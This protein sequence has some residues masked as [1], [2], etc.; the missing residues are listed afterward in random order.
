MGKGMALRWL[1]LHPSDTLALHPSIHP[2][3]YP[4]SSTPPSPPTSQL[5]GVLE[6]ISGIEKLSAGLGGAAAAASQSQQQQQ[7]Q[8][9]EEMRRGIEAGKRG[10]RTALDF[11]NGAVGGN[12]MGVPGEFA[13]S[14]E[15]TWRLVEDAYPVARNLVRG[16]GG[17]LGWGTKGGLGAGVVIKLI[18]YI[19]TPP[20]R[21]TLR[22]RNTHRSSRSTRT[23][24][25]RARSSPSSSRAASPTSRAARASPRPSC[26]C[27][28]CKFHVISY[29]SFLVLTGNA[30]F[31]AFEHRARTSRPTP[32]R[33]SSTWPTARR[34]PPHH[35]AA[36]GKRASHRRV[37]L[38]FITP[39]P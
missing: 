30:L 38:P 7:Q 32:P 14:P 17:I 1:V 24:S 20:A 15:E 12:G 25:T 34:R 19:Y 16:V 31:V 2:T 36:A 9:R 33:P 22:T 35:T 26:R 28:L 5:D 37:P 11:L 6:F 23:A 3:L 21:S 10:I 29:A 39:P 8:Q 18:G 27:V 4:P 13:P